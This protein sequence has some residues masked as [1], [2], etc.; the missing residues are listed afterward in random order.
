MINFKKESITPAHIS[1]FIA[2]LLFFILAI[3]SIG[4]AVFPFVIFLLLCAAAPF[5][6]RF[7]FFLPVISRGNSGENSVA[8][9]F[10]DG[11][12]PLTTPALLELLSRYS[13]M[14]V[15][16]VTGEKA[17]RYPELIRDILSHG[18][19]IGNHSYSHDHLLMLRSTKRLLNEIK[20]TQEILS[21]FNVKT[22]AFRPPVGI[23]NPR[24]QPVLKSLKMHCITYSCQAYDKGN[25]SIERLAG[26][27]LRKVKP[28]D[29]ILLHD[30]RTYD[31]STMKYWINEIELLLK[32]IKAKGLEIISLSEITGIDIMRIEK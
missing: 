24:L 28:D 8:L 7:G 31:E 12:D 19:S 23:T 1:G 29:I 3:F 9:T 4:L 11:P 15:F 2:F 21:K 18:H 22:Y 10:D 14:A 25:K 30:V 17:S 32:G 27:I 20:A 16:F 26:K 5:M 6:S 13:V